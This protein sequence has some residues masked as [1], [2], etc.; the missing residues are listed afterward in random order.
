MNSLSAG[1][2]D[3]EADVEG[4]GILSDYGLT[5]YFDHVTLIDQYVERSTDNYNL[6]QLK[7][8]ANCS[9]FITI[10]TVPS[11]LTRKKASD[12]PGKANQSNPKS[13]LASGV[14]ES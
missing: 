1:Y 12:M 11:T 7:V 2:H 9:G 6:T 3:I 10:E 13:V 14:P 8:M 4:I 5:S